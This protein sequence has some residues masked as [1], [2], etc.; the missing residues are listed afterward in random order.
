MS[1]TTDISIPRLRTEINGSVVAPGDREYDDARTV[2]YG[3]IDRRPSV[4]V[5]VADAGDVACVIALA[6][7]TGLEL[8]LRSGGHRHRGSLDDRGWDRPRSS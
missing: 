7:E 4:I 8:A 1:T 6:R 3:G 2:F 5:R